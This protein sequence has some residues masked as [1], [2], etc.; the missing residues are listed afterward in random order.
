[1]VGWG[2][3]GHAEGLEKGEAFQQLAPHPYPSSRRMGTES[4]P[5][6]GDRAQGSLHKT[7]PLTAFLL[8]CI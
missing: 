4:C 8:Q 6:D 2:G 5:H 3:S 1:M 7:H